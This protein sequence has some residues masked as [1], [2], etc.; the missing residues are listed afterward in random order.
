[1]VMQC[2]SLRRFSCERDEQTS[3]RWIW[4]VQRDPAWRAV[5]EHSGLRPRRQWWFSGTTTWSILMTKK[6]SRKA[7]KAL[8]KW[9]T[10]L[11][12]WAPC[13][14]GSFGF[15]QNGDSWTKQLWD[16]FKA[17]WTADN[18][19]ITMHFDDISAT[20]INHD[21]V[22]C[23]KS[24]KC[25]VLKPIGGKTEWRSMCFCKLRGMIGSNSGALR[26]HKK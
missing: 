16:H 21:S 24:Q 22:I 17:I 10:L 5:E 26:Q 18:N 8:N 9:N 12:K 13:I 14:S 4:E 1:M 23:T 20:K 6:T 2:H 11:P 25:G 19:S 7:G 3:E 15:I